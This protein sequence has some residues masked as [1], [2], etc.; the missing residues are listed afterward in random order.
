MAESA[1][2]LATYEDLLQVPPY[3]VA[4]IVNGRLVAHPRPAPRH[5][6]VSSSLGGELDG[7]F[8]K[9]LSGHRLG[10]RRNTATARHQDQ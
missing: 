6:R 5:L 7:P 2:R 10:L 4:E 1:E 8:D 9:D 3:L